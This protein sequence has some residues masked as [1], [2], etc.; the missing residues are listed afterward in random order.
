MPLLALITL[1]FAALLAGLGVGVVLNRSAL[2]RQIDAEVAELFAEVETLPTYFVASELEGLPSPVRRYLERNLSEGQ[3]HPSCVRVR[4]I[5]SVCDAPGQPWTEVAG[6]S[7]L[8]AGRPGLLSFA[9]LRPYPLV[10][11]DARTLYLRGRVNVLAKLMSS[12]STVDSSEAVQ[13]RAVLVAYLAD[14]AL[15]PPALLPGDH[16]RWEAIDDVRARA[17]VRDGELEVSGVF[18]FD[19]LGDVVAF[20][21]DDRPA[22]GSPAQS[23][24][25]ALWRVRFGEHRRF[26]DLHVP[27]LIEEEWVVGEAVLPERRRSLQAIEVDVPRRWGSPGESS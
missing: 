21:S 26:A 19:E 13:R 14:L 7:Y 3:P 10:W 4:E 25:E 1:S 9:R 2:E 15:L 27:T 16:L 5:G 17:R 20:E 18:V 8:V 24:G 23:K 11:V 6:E 12:L 22:I